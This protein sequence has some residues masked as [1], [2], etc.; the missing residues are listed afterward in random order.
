MKTNRTVVGVDTAK[1]VFQLHWVDME[2]GE[3]VRLREHLMRASSWNIC[4]NRA[5]MPGGDGSV[6][7]HAALGTPASGTSVTRSGFLPAKLVRPDRYG[8]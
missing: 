7:W 1:R 2:T 3:I 4:A 6:R 8:R 5:P